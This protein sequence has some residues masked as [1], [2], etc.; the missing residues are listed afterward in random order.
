MGESWVEMAK[1]I[2]QTEKE[3]YVTGS[4]INLHEH[5]IFEG[6]NR[7]QS[8]KYGLKVWLRADFHNMS[9]RGVH[10]DKAF[11]LSLKRMAQKKAME[12]YGWDIPKF[13]SIFGRNYL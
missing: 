11:D 7:K 10:F 8:E 13:I 12:H 3:C 6:S 9:D 2:I 4:T 1:S 5:H